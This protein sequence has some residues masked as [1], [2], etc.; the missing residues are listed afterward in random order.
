MEERI[1]GIEDTMGKINM[2]I[3]ENAKSKKV[4]DT[5]HPKNLVHYENT[6]PKN[7]RNRRRS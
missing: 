6:N 5:K 3:K 7:S 4:H 2:S 1:A